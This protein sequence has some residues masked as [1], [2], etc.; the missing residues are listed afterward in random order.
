MTDTENPQ[1]GLDLERVLSKVER[2]LLGGRRRYTRTEVA[3]KAGVDLEDAK[4]LW[5]SLG[6][7]NTDDDAKLF[8]DGDVAALVQTQR[9]NELVG[10]DMELQTA[11]GRLYGQVFSRL[12]TLQTQM[13]MEVVA[14]NPEML[15]D[16]DAIVRFVDRAMP[17]LETVQNYVW[18]RQVVAYFDRIVSQVIRMEADE[19]GAGTARVVGFADMSGFTTFTRSASESDLREIL[20]QFED[21]T[22]TVIGAHHGRIV[23]TIGDEVLFIVDDAKAAAEIA[24]ALVEDT[25]DNDRMPPLRVGMAAGPVL[26]RLGD[27]YGS[28]VNIASRLTTSARPGTVLIDRELH[29]L[30]AGD[31]GY[32]LR[33]RR[34]ENVRGFAHLRN[35][36]L[37]RAVNTRGWDRVPMPGEV[38]SRGADTVR[39]TVETFVD[40]LPGERRRRSRAQSADLPGVDTESAE[41]NRSHPADADE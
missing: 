3:A 4:K 28:T 38:V 16:G 10:T 6:F 5:A 36:R 7:A 34:S 32:Y 26:D 17:I 22:T 2:K 40:T 21:V 18:R 30:L 12:A 15:A 14:S 1:L 41:Q 11:I 8:T 23:K 31:E 9:L 29:D 24:L 37:Q 33:G 39:Q 35:W 20:E 13:M 19:P 27:V 25:D